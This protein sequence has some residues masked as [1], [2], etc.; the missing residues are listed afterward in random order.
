MNIAIIAPSPAPFAIG[1]AEKLFWGLLDYLN[2]RTSHRAELIKLPCRE[3][4]FAEVLASY[5]AFSQLDLNHFDLI[6]STKYPSW[7]VQHEQHV[8]Y[9]LHPLRGLYDTYPEGWLLAVPGPHDGELGRLLAVLER[10][11]GER[12]ALTEVFERAERL[13]E[14]RDQYPPE[15]L[16]FP[17]PLARTVVHFLDG[18]GLAPG[19][20]CRYAAISRTVAG[21]T[22]YFPSDVE[23]AVAYPPSLLKIPPN[24]PL[25]KRGARILPSAALPFHSDPLPREPYLFTVSRLDRPK[26]LDLLVEAM[27]RVEVP[28]KLKIAG[29]GPDE[30]RL[31]ALARDDPRIEFPGF[32]NDD[33][34]V[35]YYAQA[36]AVPYVPDREDFGLVTLEAMLSGKPV[37]TALDAGGPNEL[38]VDGETGY[39][40]APEPE[41]LAERITF[42]ATHQDEAQRLGEQGWRRVQAICWEQV[43]ATLLGEIPPGLPLSKE[44]TKIPPAPFLVKENGH[45]HKLTVATTF[46]VFPP[47]GGGQ[48]RV[49]HL[50]RHLAKVCDVDLVTFTEYGEPPLDREIAPGLREI[51]VPKSRTHRDAEGQM[52]GEVG[53]IP[54]GDVTMPELYQRTPAYGRALARSVAGAD[55][56]VACHPYLLP[57][58]REAGERPLWYEAQD[59]EWQLK[60]EILPD[61][62]QGR[63]LL[64]RVRELEAQCCAESQL[65]LVCAE[66]DGETLQRLYGA[67]PARLIEVANGVDL[68][69]VSYTPLA[70]RRL[71]QRRLR[72][73]DAST[74]LF[75]GSWHGPNLEAVESLLELATA[76]PEWRF[77]VVGSAG[78]AFQGRS[79]PP[80]LALLGVVDDTMKD[81]LLSVV[82]VALNPITSGSGT[83]LKMLDYLAAGVPVITTGFGARGLDLTPE[84]VTFAEP[85]DLAAALDALR[86]EPEADQEQRIE[87][88]RQYMV[89]RFDWQVIAEG[90]IAQAGLS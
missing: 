7:M 48:S 75:M 63:A 43:A 11:P 55:V 84:Q 51:R 89:A 15:L 68:A 45:R 34:V 50:Y 10:Y 4:D 6:I 77:L 74:A 28:I 30:A 49:Y 82:D 23:V 87:A 65:I 36:L 46:P 13:I 39:S 3:G 17:G 33:E 61:N 29:T 57:A 58:L 86:T 24:P 16:A 88:A 32:V 76:R 52:A 20:V 78:L 62:T 25:S 59:V 60:R 26:R 67:D 81:T 12:A 41:A 80:N 5:Q 22:G 69:S 54:V 85:A 31:R 40:V 9:M 35:R 47:R 38:V 44:E 21:R 19:A 83:N 71:A 27:R 64:E 8:C 73:T 66:R 42:L 53:N 79:A 56:V 18:V 90:F 37:L 2:Q 1:G 72:L 14:Q 70:Q